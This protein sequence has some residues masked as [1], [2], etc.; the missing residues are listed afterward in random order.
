MQS[1]VPPRTVDRKRLTISRL[2]Y[3][4][5]SRETSRICLKFLK[6]TVP[7][8]ICPRFP[9]RR[10]P[11]TY[12]PLQPAGVPHISDY[13]PICNLKCHTPDH[14]GTCFTSVLDKGLDF[15]HDCPGHVPTY[16]LVY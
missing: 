10:C 4:P 12:R 13:M 14:R 8:E 7:P 11:E 16:L 2:N 9:E 1:P 3:C 5:L 6:T 15:C